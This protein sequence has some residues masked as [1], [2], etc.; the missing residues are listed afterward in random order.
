MWQIWQCDWIASNPNFRVLK[1]ET[2]KIIEMKKKNK[3][4]KKK[5]LKK[6]QKKKKKK[7]K[8]K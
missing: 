6:N 5:K 2:C 7:T 3:K 1:I 4:K 8:K